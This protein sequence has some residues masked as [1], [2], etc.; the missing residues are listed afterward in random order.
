MN[1]QPNHGFKEH[2]LMLYLTPSL[3]LGFIKLQGEKELG[4]ASIENNANSGLDRQV[5][6]RTA[7]DTPPSFNLT[8]LTSK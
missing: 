7:N 5:S 2:G 8:E 1:E 4:R 6:A 3:Y